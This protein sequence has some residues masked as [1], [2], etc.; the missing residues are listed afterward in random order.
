MRD[1]G[2]IPTVLDRIA[3]GVAA[4]T[5][6]LIGSAMAQGGRGYPTP[7]GVTAQVTGSST[8][9]VTW[10]AGGMATG[11]FVYRFRGTV[12]EASSPELPGTATQWNDGPAL[13]S[14]ALQAGATYKYIVK[15]VYAGNNSTT[16]SVTITMPVASIAV[17]VPPNTVPVA[18]PG[19]SSGSPPSGL[20]ADATPTSILIRWNCPTGSV[21]FDVYATPQGGQQGKLT[22]TPVPVP[23]VQDLQT[24]PTVG[25][26]MTAPST[27]AP[28]YSASYTHSGLIPGS[29]FTYVVRALYPNGFAASTP[30]TAQ[31]KL[32]PAAGGFVVTASGR[33]AGMSWQPVTGATGYQIFRKL[34]SQSTFLQLTNTA[35]GATSY[36]DQTL[37]AP[38][39]HQYYV[40]AVNGLPTS[41]FTLS[42]PAWPAP[43]GFTATGAGFSVNLSWHAVAGTQGYLVYRQLQNESGF[44]QL[45]ATPQSATT[46]QDNNLL[47]TLRANYYAKAVDGDATA[48]VSAVPG[49]P[50]GVGAQTYPG[51]SIVDFTWSGTAGATTIQV[52]RAPTQSG[53]FT[54][55]TEVGALKNWARTSQGQVGT[56]YFKV[57]AK[58]YAIGQAESD[59]VAVTI[60]PPLPPITN[61]RATSPGPGVVKLSWDCYPGATSYTI[62]RQQGSAPAAWITYPGSAEPLIVNGCALDDTVSRLAPYGYSYTVFASNGGSGGTS[63]TTAP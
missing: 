54:D 29:T 50:V 27:T 24:A 40:Q 44:K 62:L 49:R 37:L 55:V 17:A 32:L 9:Q 34:A 61:V 1:T 26:G 11:Y 19:A 59:V 25:P 46:Y 45:T 35:A 41:T 38:G 31:A 4:L 8:A 16:A 47:P 30:L 39:Q 36:T 14:P 23:C 57:S 51:S 63:V 10:L 12:Q 15:A 42:M 6:S 52:L 7:T 5:L 13:Q 53:A 20:R 43:S 21:G 28:T 3:C 2:R 58:Y 56:Q 60:P 18:P 33:S 22:S 48:V